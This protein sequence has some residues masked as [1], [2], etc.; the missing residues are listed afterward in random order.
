MFYICEA[1][2]LPSVDKC[3]GRWPIKPTRGVATLRSKSINQTG[4]KSNCPRSGPTVHC[5]MC[6]AVNSI[7][8]C[9]GFSST[10]PT[11]HCQLGSLLA[12][13]TN[14][15]HNQIRILFARHSD[16]ILNK[17]NKILLNRTRVDT[18]NDRIHSLIHW[19]LRVCSSLALTPTI[20][21]LFRC[22][23][24]LFIVRYRHKARDAAYGVIV[25]LNSSNCIYFLPI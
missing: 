15:P 18:A 10:C 21:R 17:Y 22:K 25:L 8:G 5:A 7:C 11:S 13:Q 6:T 19:V 4:N 14:K 3:C 23:L 24:W 20:I 9:C 12:T 1:R 16:A 2:D